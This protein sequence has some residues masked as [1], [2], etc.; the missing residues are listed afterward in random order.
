MPLPGQT[1]SKPTDSFEII[2]LNAQLGFLVP[3]FTEELPVIAIAM[4]VTNQMLCLPHSP[5]WLFGFYS[6]MRDDL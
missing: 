1:D 4:R 3:N 5:V 2:D 6:V